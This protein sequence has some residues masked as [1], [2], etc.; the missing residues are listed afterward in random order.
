LY[1]NDPDRH[2]VELYWDR[3]KTSWPLKPDGT[4]DMFTKPLNLQELLQELH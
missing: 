1:L 2:G 4:I 3:P